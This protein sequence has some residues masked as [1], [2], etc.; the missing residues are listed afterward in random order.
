MK[1]FNQG[2]HFPWQGHICPGFGTKNEE[3]LRMSRKGSVEKV[4]K[5]A[6]KPFGEMKF[7]N[8]DVRKQID[9]IPLM[10]IRSI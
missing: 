3:S 6:E 2:A 7:F 9:R 4:Q 1:K 5:K 10:G 8:R